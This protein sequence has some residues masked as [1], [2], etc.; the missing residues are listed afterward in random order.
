VRLEVVLVIL[1]GL[2]VPA[3]VLEVTIDLVFSALFVRDCGSSFGNP[4]Y[5]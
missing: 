1:G 3:A 2:V 4:S 5:L